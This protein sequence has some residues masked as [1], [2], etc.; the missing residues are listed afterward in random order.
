MNL[1]INYAA[2]ACLMYVVFLQGYNFVKYRLLDGANQK[3]LI[4]LICTVCMIL[5]VIR[6]I[7][8]DAMPFLLCAAIGSVFL[9]DGFKWPRE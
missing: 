6:R 8:D 5:H 3:R 9:Y 4:L 7:H 1:V 2:F